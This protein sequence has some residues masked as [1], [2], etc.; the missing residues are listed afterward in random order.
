MKHMIVGKHLFRN[1]VAP[2][3][4]ENEKELRI[5]PLLLPLPL[6][7]PKLATINHKHLYNPYLT[8][9]PGPVA[10][11]RTHLTQFPL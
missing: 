2:P 5:A 10:R 4:I 7:K 8:T 1:L 9:K 11:A 6:K 3:A